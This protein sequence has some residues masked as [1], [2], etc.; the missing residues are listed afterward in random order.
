LLSKSG[1]IAH[2]PFF[3]D[4]ENRAVM[5]YAPKS[6]AIFGLKFPA[7]DTT[8]IRVEVKK[9]N[10]C[11]RNIVLCLTYFANKCESERSLASGMPNM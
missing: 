2:F 9:Y 8:N 6:I 11:V 1:Y 4:D 10:L 5:L 3:Y 7:N